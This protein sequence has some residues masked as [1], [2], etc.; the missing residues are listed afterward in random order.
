MGGNPVGLTGKVQPAWTYNGAN[1]D[2]NQDMGS[3]G[4]VKLFSSSANI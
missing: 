1:G 2:L 3:G 4:V